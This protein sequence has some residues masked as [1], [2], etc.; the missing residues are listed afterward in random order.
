MATSTKDRKTA[1]QNRTTLD[2][3]MC[4]RV[5]MHDPTFTED[6][7]PWKCL[8]TFK[9]LTCC[10]DYIADCQDKRVDVVFQSPADTRIVRHDETRVAW[11][12]E[13]VT[14]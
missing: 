9:Y 2:D 6:E 7:R 4:F 3:T 14:A 8:A 10:L 12:P 13:P 5:W 1:P 11:R